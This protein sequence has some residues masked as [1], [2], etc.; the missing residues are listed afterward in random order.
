MRTMVRELMHNNSSSRLCK[1]RSLRMKN[2]AVS[3]ISNYRCGGPMQY[4]FY[5]NSE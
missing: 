3:V 2:E 4:V 1:Y 5:R